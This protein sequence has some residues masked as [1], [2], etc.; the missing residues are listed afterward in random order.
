MNNISFFFL[1]YHH[2]I[3]GNGIMA[4]ENNPEVKVEPSVPDPIILAQIHAL[5]NMTQKLYEASMGSENVAWVK[6]QGKN[7]AKY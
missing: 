5:R 6:L 2:P 1:R 4:N 3:I 7:C